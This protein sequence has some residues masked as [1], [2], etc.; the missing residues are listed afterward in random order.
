MFPSRTFSVSALSE[1][2]RVSPSALPPK[3]AALWTLGQEG[4][5]L[6]TP[7]LRGPRGLPPLWIPAQEA[8]PL[9]PAKGCAPLEP[10][11]P[12][13]GKDAAQEKRP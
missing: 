6:W 2:R 10:R 1:G 8:P 3:S 12:L 9:H 5:A 4:P 7:A 13:R 11:W